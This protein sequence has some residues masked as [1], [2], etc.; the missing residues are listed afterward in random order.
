MLVTV[1]IYSHTLINCEAVDWKF[2]AGILEQSMGTINRV[3]IRFSYRPASRLHRQADR[4]LG[5][6]SW[7]PL[8]MYKYRL[9]FTSY[10]SVMV[11]IERKTQLL[12]F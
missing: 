7:A 9:C 1:I 12:I 4:F 5:I 10:C 8:K 3:G 6:D 11:L 2:C